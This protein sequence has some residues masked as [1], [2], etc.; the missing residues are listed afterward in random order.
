[1]KKCI[2]F[3]LCITQYILSY[4]QVITTVA[5]NG[6]PGDS[7]D[8]GPATNA[9]I[10][11]PTLVVFDSHGNYFFTENSNKVREVNAC[12]IISTIAGTGTAGFSGDSSLA[13]NAELN[14]PLGVAID[15]FDNIYIS[16]FG[17][18][19][20][21]KVDAITGII[22]TYAGN[23][24]FSYGGDSG[25]AINASIKG[26]S[27]IA[28]DTFGNLYISDHGNNRIRKVDAMGI[29]TTYAGNGLGGYGGTGGLA[30]T[31]KISLPQ[32]LIC[33]IS[34]NIFFIEGGCVGVRKV[35]VNTGIITTVA[36]NGTV[37]FSGD[38]G[39]AT[40]AQFYAPVT[41]AIDRIGN[42]YIADK[43]NERV[44]IVDS[45]GMV[46]T[47][48]GTG[49]AGY[50]GDG[51]LADTAKLYYPEGVACDSV[52]NLFIADFVNN[53]IRKVAFYPSLSCDELSVNTNSYIRNKI[54]IYPNPATNQLTITAGEVINNVVMVNIVGEVVKSIDHPLPILKTGGEFEIDVSG[55]VNGVY[56]VRV[57]GEEWRRFLKE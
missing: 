13:T 25:L 16:D 15:K 37:G 46:N 9:K 8:N 38:S 7:G 45:L 21:R 2:C 18:N 30:D 50:S 1:M 4:S 41:V 52:G 20:I 22:T 27:G 31:T 17:N 28:C 55:L 48:V 56:F 42:I 5:G 29:M 40:L 39:P 11:Y 34:G 43:G 23:G 44:R 3:L 10:D 19:R 54:T 36:G 47:V 51:G 33:D 32:G 14:R 26:S 49:V 53:R 6:L 35:N 57:N 12:G 24:D